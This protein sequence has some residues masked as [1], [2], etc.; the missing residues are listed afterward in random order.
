MQSQREIIIENMVRPKQT[1]CEEEVRN[2][3]CYS[4]SLMTITRQ[5]MKSTTHGDRP[6]TNK[7]GILKEGKNGIKDS[8]LREEQ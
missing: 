2:K 1:N 7:E 3:V 6:N 5:E 4:G 8:E